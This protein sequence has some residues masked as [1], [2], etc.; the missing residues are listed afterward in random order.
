VAIVAGVLEQR[1]DLCRRRV[2]GQQIAPRLDRRIEMRGVGELQRGAPE[3]NDPSNP[4]Q[5]DSHVSIKPSDAPI[6]QPPDVA[7]KYFREKKVKRSRGQ[8]AGR[9]GGSTK[10]RIYFQW[11][12]PAMNPSHFGVIQ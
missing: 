11:F 9:A 7:A 5:P 6:F 4:F 10:T 8:T 3:Q 1:N 12:F 2:A